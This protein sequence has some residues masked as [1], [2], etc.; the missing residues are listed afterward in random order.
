[1]KNGPQLAHTY[2]RLIK[3]YNFQIILFES[4]SESG[5]FYSYGDGS[6]ILSKDL[7]LEQPYGQNLFLKLNLYKSIDEYE[8]YFIGKGYTYSIF[9]NFEEDNKKFN[10]ITR[11][12]NQESL[13]LSSVKLEEEFKGKKYINKP[14]NL[15]FF[16]AILKGVDPITSE[17]LPQG[18]AWLHPKIISDI[19][20]Y[21]EITKPDKPQNTNSLYT[22]N[23][24]SFDDQESYRKE[25]AQSLE[26][27]N[28]YKPW[29][30]EEEQTLL[31][32]RNKTVKEISLILKRGIGAIKSRLKKLDGKNYDSSSI[33]DIFEKKPTDD[34][35]TKRIKQEQDKASENIN[36]IKP[37]VNKKVG[38][39][40]VSCGDSFDQRRKDLGI[41]TCLKC[42]EIVA[43]RSSA[44]INEGIAGTREEN[45]KMNA[46]IWGE[47]R[48][49]SRGN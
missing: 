34:L 29:S 13:H 35:Q 19:K 37:K 8:Q 15:R 12:S 43:T 30:P 49:R 36:N 47:M 33:K 11:T 3:K 1:M 14:D 26:M 48:N 40:C 10:K 45:K 31:S 42:G 23:G 6:I 17:I 21:I 18:S 41:S 39:I 27:N 2:R 38:P 28:A 32:S 16:S 7:N 20:E 9:E 25:L 4:R 24:K 46:Q 22:Y 44:R 5:I